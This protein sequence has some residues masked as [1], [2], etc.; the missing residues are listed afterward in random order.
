MADNTDKFL[1]LFS[2]ALVLFWVTTTPE[3]TYQV[4]EIQARI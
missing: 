4:K 1:I 2:Q 3:K